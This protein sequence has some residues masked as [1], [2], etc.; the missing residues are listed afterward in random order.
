MV[1]AEP[2]V[3]RVSRLAPS[4][5]STPG[6]VPH[7]VAVCV[8]VDRQAVHRNRGV[9]AGARARAIGEVDVVGGRLEM[10]LQAAVGQVDDRLVEIGHRGAGIVG[11]SQPVQV[12]VGIGPVLVGAYG[13]RGKDA[14]RRV[15]LQD[16]VEQVHPAIGAGLQQRRPA[17]VWRI[18]EGGP[19]GVAVVDQQGLTEI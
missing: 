13:V 11:P 17:P 18:G 6:P 5:A 10:P 14:A 19:G 9:R 8:V 7:H 1:V 4:Q 12:V 3:I 16:L 2:S 15:A